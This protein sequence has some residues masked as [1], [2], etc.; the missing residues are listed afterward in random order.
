[1]GREYVN[2]RTVLTQSSATR[3]Q[4]AGPWGRGYANKRSHSFDRRV[5]KIIRGGAM[6]MKSPETASPGTVP[7]ASF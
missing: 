2:E 1:M 7:E 5:G 3:S 4:Q 6:Q